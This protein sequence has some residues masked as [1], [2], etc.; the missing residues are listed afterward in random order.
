M[1]LACWLADLLRPLSWPHPTPLSC[2][3]SCVNLPVLPFADPNPDPSACK[4]YLRFVTPLPRM[5]AVCLHGALYILMTCSYSCK[6]H[7]QEILLASSDMLKFLPETA[8]GVTPPQSFVLYFDIC[9]IY[10]NCFLSTAWNYVT[11][12]HH[13]L[14]TLLTATCIMWHTSPQQWP[15][16]YVKPRTFRY[17]FLQ[18]IRWKIMRAQL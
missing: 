6:V 16:K 18:I 9:L 11:L 13:S 17:T 10:I 15:A 1:C 7:E 3:C 12:Y 5:T 8:W 4:P 2:S 14:F